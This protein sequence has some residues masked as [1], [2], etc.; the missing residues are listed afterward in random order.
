MSSHTP[1][2]NFTLGR[3]LALHFYPLKCGAELQS[4]ISIKDEAGGTEELNTIEVTKVQILTIL[5]IGRF[6][7][8]YLYSFIHS[9]SIC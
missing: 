2:G 4:S 9:F 3:A 7:G 5:Q 8:M 6:F 1:L